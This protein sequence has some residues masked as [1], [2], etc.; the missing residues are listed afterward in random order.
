MT[1]FILSLVPRV[2]TNNQQVLIM[3][4]YSTI[5]H[6]LKPQRFHIKQAISVLVNSI[7]II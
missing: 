1:I 3:S 2:E 4:I 6:H 5:D 7:I